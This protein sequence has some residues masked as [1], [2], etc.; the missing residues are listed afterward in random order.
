MLELQR[1]HRVENPIEAKDGVDDHG[2]VVHPNFLVT[3][4]LSQEWVLSTWVAETPI[5][6]NIP[7]TCVDGVDGGKSDEERAMCCAFV[8][9]VDA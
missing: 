4:G 8:D 2:G 5:I 1:Y 7:E 3:Q 6:V 9:A